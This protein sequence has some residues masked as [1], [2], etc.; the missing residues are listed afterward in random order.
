MFFNI[1]SFLIYFIFQDL[2]LAI[3]R[4]ADFLG[5]SFADESEMISLVDHLSISKMKE[6]TAENYVKQAEIAQN[7]LKS[8]G[9]KIEFIRKGTTCQWKEYMT[10][11]MIERFDKWII[12]N[13]K[14]YKI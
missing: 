11:E 3:R 5:Y 7:L 14:K 9:P 4:V 12:E 2:P 10:E 8:D 6:R 1:K 13:L